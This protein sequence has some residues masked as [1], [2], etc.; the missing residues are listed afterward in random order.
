MNSNNNRVIRLGKKS[1]GTQLI[2]NFLLILI[3]FQRVDPP[4]PHFSHSLSIARWRLN[5]W[6]NDKRNR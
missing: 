2:F 3:L 1:E 6:R 5:P 4:L